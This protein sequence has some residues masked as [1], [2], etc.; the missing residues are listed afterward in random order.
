MGLDLPEKIG[1]NGGSKRG[2]CFRQGEGRGQMLARGRGDAIE[3]VHQMRA[4]GCIPRSYRPSSP[5]VLGGDNE[6]TWGTSFTF[7]PVQLC[8]GR[9]EGIRLN[10]G[11]SLPGIYPLTLYGEQRLQPD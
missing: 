10:C 6:P 1:S 4:T 11:G 8:K 7:D 3:G 2:S 5:K 9:R